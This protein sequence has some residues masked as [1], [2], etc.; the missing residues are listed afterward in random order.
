[1]RRAAREDLGREAVGVG[2]QR[3]RRDDAHELPVAGRRVLA[4]AERVQAT[5]EHGLGGGRDARQRHDRSR[6]PAAPASGGRGRRPPRRGARACSRPRRRSR[7]RPVAHRRRR[8]RGRSRRRGGS[9]RRASS[10]CQ[11]SRGAPGP[12]PRADGR[13]SRRPAGARPRG[14]CRSASSRCR[15]GRAS[16]AASAGRSRPRGDAWRTCG[17]ACAGSSAR[18]GPRRRVALHDLVEPLA[19][20]AVPRWLT[21]RRARRRADERGRPAAR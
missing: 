10:L 13:R 20:Q 18:R 16:P 12:A 2:R 11:S 3:R 6:A 9:W 7:R 1:M 4:R 21:K 14:A 8:R 15:R 19:G 17:A 5:V